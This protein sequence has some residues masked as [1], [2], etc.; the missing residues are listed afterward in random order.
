M[1][2]SSLFLSSSSFDDKKITSFMKSLWLWEK[3]DESYPILFNKN[4]LR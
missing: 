4:Y 1:K 3:D 2:Y